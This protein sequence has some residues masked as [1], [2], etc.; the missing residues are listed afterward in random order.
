MV[1]SCRIIAFCFSTAYQMVQASDTSGGESR[2]LSHCSIIEQ[3][4]V[5]EKVVQGAVQQQV[6]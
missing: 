5:L 3:F 4:S 1:Q 6:A 2:R